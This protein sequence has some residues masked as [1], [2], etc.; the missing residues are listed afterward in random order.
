MFKTQPMVGIGTAF[1]ISLLMASFLSSFLQIVVIMISLVIAAALAIGY[2]Q[3]YA[4]VILAL[5]VV[6]FGTGIY[7]LKADK[8]HMAVE[9]YSESELVV[10]A[11]I[12]DAF[13]NKKGT[14]GYDLLIM[15]CEGIKTS[16]P[17]KIRVYS[18]QEMTAQIGDI[19]TWRV[20]LSEP[21]NSDTFDSKQYYQSQ[22]IYLTGFVKREINQMTPNHRPSRYWFDKINHYFCEK[23]DTL[24]PL[25]EA[26]LVK[27]M[28]LGN[29][30]SIGLSIARNFS[31]SGV[32]HIIAISGLHLTILSG[33]LLWLCQRIGISHDMCRI[34]TIMIIWMF[35]GVAGFP[36]SALRSGLMLTVLMVGGLFGRSAVSLNSLFLSGIILGLANPFVIHD[37]GFQMTFLSCLGLFLCSKPIGLW[38]QRKLCG[39]KKAVLLRQACQLTAMSLSTLLFLF[40][41]FLL[42]FDGISIAGILTNLLVIPLVP[43]ILTSGM[44]AILISAVSELS[45]IAEI[46]SLLPTLLLRVISQVVHWVAQIPFGY[47]GIGYGDI[48]ALL[49]LGSLLLMVIFLFCKKK[50]KQLLFCG[51]IALLVST[52][53][54]SVSKW[55]ET[56]LTTISTYSGK[57]VVIQQRDKVAVIE[58][59]ADSYLQ[60]E[61]V[62]FMDSRNISEIE[63]LI[64]LEEDMHFTDTLPYLLEAKDIQQV[65]L[66]DNHPVKPYFTDKYSGIEQYSQFPANIILSEQMHLFLNL[67]GEKTGVWANLNGKMFCMTNDTMAAQNAKCEI[68]F[69]NK[70]KASQM[71]HFYSKYV[72]MLN[73]CEL[74]EETDFS[75]LFFAENQRYTILISPQGKIRVLKE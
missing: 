66:S 72:I 60:R 10:T 54:I 31:L 57:A 63:H 3:K 71:E 48:K 45:F 35:V 11:T 2:K 58:F 46:I 23:V 15:D 30:D 34:C 8:M 25:Q 17:F 75:R 24:F 41:V 32:Y 13:I 28:L 62:G 67:D 59:S 22:E 26:G 14:S 52:I 19:V 64:L 4:G 21:N 37:I 69:F 20:E 56:Q 12:Q 1:L 40:P 50:R 51:M 70:E 38:L 73:E 42:S 49:L 74:S 5:V 29:R 16:Y 33:I 43:L 27:A 55:N 18:V 68:L 65:Y 39:N 44:I 6:A 61:L 9:Q 7:G 53:C 36:I 47:I